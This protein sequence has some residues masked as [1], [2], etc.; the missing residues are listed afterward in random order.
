MDYNKYHVCT[1]TTCMMMD[2]MY[3]VV[4]DLPQTMSCVSLPH[5]SLGQMIFIS[6]TWPCQ[7]AGNGHSLFIVIIGRKEVVNQLNDN[8]YSTKI[9]N[10]V[11]LSR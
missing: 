5:D 4:D 10:I 1:V 3:T 2:Y 11:S 8:I 9:N 6:S 7:T